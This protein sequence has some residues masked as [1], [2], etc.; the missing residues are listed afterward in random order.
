M[1]LADYRVYWTTKR[2]VSVIYHAEK[3]HKL[4]EVGM[5]HMAD[6]EAIR[7]S[8]CPVTS[9]KDWSPRGNVRTSS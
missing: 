3:R 1:L 8:D 9:F 4:V 2:Q 5:G 6:Q 7:L